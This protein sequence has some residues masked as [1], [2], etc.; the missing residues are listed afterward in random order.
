MK[1]KTKKTYQDSVVNTDNENESIGKLVSYRQIR[2]ARNFVF[3]GELGG[4]NVI[5]LPID[6]LTLEWLYI[7]AFSE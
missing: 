4:V 3:L 5:S 6:L 2:M 7:L 1:K